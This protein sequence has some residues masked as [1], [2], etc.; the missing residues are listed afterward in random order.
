MQVLDVVVRRAIVGDGVIDKVENIAVDRHLRER[1][2]VVDVGVRRGAVRAI[3]AESVRVVLVRPSCVTIA[4]ARELPAVL[5]RE[6]PVCTLDEVAAFIVAEAPAV[7][8]GEQ[9]SPAARVVRIRERFDCLTEVAGSVGIFSFA[10]D[11]SALIVRPRPGLARGLVVLADEL[12]RGVVGV[13]CGVFAVADGEDVAVAVVGVRVGH[14][15]HG[16][17]NG[18]G[19]LRVIEYSSIIKREY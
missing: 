14:V 13:A 11:V 16:G 5:P 6:N 15:V 18:Y 4:Y 2:A 19:C 7:V 3:G 9:I 10:G 1:T 8:H 12:I 17:V